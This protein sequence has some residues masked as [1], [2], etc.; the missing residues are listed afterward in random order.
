MRM[1]P[2][3]SNPIH[4]EPTGLMVSQI[5]YEQ[6]RPKLAIIRGPEGL[7]RL[8]AT[9]RILDAHGA[10]I[11]EKPWRAWGSRWGSSWWQGDFTELNT[12]GEFTLVPGSPLNPDTFEIGPD[13]L[14]EKTHVWVGIEQAERRSRLA[15]NGVGWQDCGAQWQE[16]NSHAIYILGFCDL[17]ELAHDRLSSDHLHR[18]AL[19][20]IN[21]CDYLALLQDHAASLGLGNGAVSHQKPKYGEICLPSDVAKAVAAWSRAARLLPAE[22][23]TKRTEYIQRARASVN[24]LSTCPPPDHA[25]FSRTN[26]GAA[27]DFEP[28]REWMTRDLL[29]R[30]GGLLDLVHS[31]TPCEAEAFA[32]AEQIMARQ[33]TPSALSDGFYGHFRTFDTSMLTEKA[34][35]HHIDSGVFGSDA[36]AHVPHDVSPLIRMCHRWPRHP[37]AAQWRQ[38]VIDFA[39]GYLLPA[40]R[41]SP[42]MILPL[43]L[44]PGQGILHFAGLWHGMNAAYASIA[45]LARD[46]AVFLDDPVFEEVA[47]GNLQWIAGLNAG[48]TTASLASSHMF[49]MQI[50]PGVAC[51]TSMI[52]GIGK[53]WA[54]T[55]L[56]VRGSIC[57]GF[58]TGDQFR[59]DIEPTVAN[60]GPRMFTDEDWVT[61]AGAWLSAI[62]RGV[63]TSLSRRSVTTSTALMG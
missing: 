1:N 51:S 11:L 28:P 39:Y 19:Q 21:G 6:G 25:G 31:G 44:F 36:G 46:L 17:L 24:W 43:G 55:W 53:R 32:L 7:L 40:C 58:S 14:W 34:W 54:G 41:S 35:T 50:P 33:V 2:P 10:C 62:S 30:L 42:F 59:F 60:D 9:F 13:I 18:A 52:C 23:N 5:G 49:S 20:I 12:A 56:N 37:A 15:M 63:Q 4:P 3:P 48:V 47:T 27:R 29:M 16:A 26:H 57:N 61:H 22:F 38:A 8:G 45:A